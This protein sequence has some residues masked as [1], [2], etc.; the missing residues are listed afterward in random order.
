MNS[1]LLP[2]QTKT[3]EEFSLIGG[4]FS[5]AQTCHE[6]NTISSTHDKK[7]SS[8][9]AELN[10]DLHLNEC[11]SV[12]LCK[13][14][15]TIEFIR[16]KPS[17]LHHQLLKTPNIEELKL[18]KM[19]IEIL[20]GQL[21]SWTGIIMSIQKQDNTASKPFDPSA[22]SYNLI[23]VFK[24]DELK[25]TFYHHHSVKNSTKLDRSVSYPCLDSFFIAFESV[26]K[27]HFRHL[28]INKYWHEILAISFAPCR[29][30][31]YHWY[32]KALD[33]HQE[34]TWGQVK[35]TIF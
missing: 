1:Q 26:F 14:Q 5:L 6:L 35:K 18:I 17:A 11:I 19:K 24:I 21:S 27:H 12:V 20:E 10:I 8:P 13:A 7:L 9:V 15:N 23:P 30:V 33:C 34:L 25:D 32:Q 22:V 31:I 28:S 3:A 4:S 2:S 16:E 29:P